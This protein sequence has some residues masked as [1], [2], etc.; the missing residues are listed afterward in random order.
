MG[1]HRLLFATSVLAAITAT[2]C[3]AGVEVALQTDEQV[4]HLWELVHWEWAVSNTGDSP[5]RIYFSDFFD[6]SQSVKLTSSEGPIH[7]TVLWEGGCFFCWSAALRSRSASRIASSRT[8]V[9]A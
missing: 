2:P 7:Y 5:V 9:K 4:I 3:R 1:A 6:L 8:V